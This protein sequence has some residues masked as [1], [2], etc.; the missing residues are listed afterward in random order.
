MI[1]KKTS[2][3]R[4]EV[5]ADGTVQV[6]FQKQIV[7]DGNVIFAEPHRTIFPP[8]SD[9]DRQM[10]AVNLDLEAM[11]FPPV[12]DYPT[13]SA[14]VALA[15]TKETVAAYRKKTTAASEQSTS[16]RPDESSR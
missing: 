13:L 15:H 7:E 12:Y 2:L 3:D 5:L 1:E 4:I 6:R 9:V 14:H 16:A 11:G 10:M 8:G